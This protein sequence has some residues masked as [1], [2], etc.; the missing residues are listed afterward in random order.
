VSAYLCRTITTPDVSAADYRAVEPALLHELDLAF[1][2]DRFEGATPTGQRVLEAMAREPGQIRL[3]RLRP[4][5]RDVRA[6]IS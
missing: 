5:V 6:S 3:T 2:E 1:C 4:H